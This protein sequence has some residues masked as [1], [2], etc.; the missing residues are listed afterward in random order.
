MYEKPKVISV[1]PTLNRERWEGGKDFKF[2]PG[3]RLSWGVVI[4]PTRGRGEPMMKLQKYF[5]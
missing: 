2:R 5:S 1:L 4:F 3:E